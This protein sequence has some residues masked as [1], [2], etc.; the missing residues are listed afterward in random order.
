M[1]VGTGRSTEKGVW[2]AAVFVVTVGS[3]ERGVMES[4]GGTN[5]GGSMEQEGTNEEG[6]SSGG[7]DPKGRSMGVHGE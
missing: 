5:V 2:R 3:M 7:T 6:A 4:Q 1:L